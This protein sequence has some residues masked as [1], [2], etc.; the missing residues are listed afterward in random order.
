M[1]PLC[2]LILAWPLSFHSQSFTLSRPV[3]SLSLDKDGVIGHVIILANMRI[4]V[5]CQFHIHF[6]HSP[7]APVFLYPH[8]LAG[9]SP[10]LAGGQKPTHPRANIE[11]KT[12]GKKEQVKLGAHSALATL[13][14]LLPCDPTKHASATVTLPWL[15][16]LL[17]TLLPWRI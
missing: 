8:P 2:C 14:S 3:I 4:L 9:S 13:V 12:I 17:G 7:P 5:F 11:C 10:T 6:H 1:Q 15:L 16:S